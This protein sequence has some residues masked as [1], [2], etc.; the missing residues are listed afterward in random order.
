MA[1]QD[2]S[3]EKTEEPTEK[4]LQDAKKK[5]Q[6]PRSR[7]LNTLLSLVAAAISM[8]FLGQ[9]LI[10]DLFDLMT[11]SLAFDLQVIKNPELMFEQISRSVAHGLGALAPLFALFVFAAF[12]GP[13]AMGGMVIQSRIPC[14]KA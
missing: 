7:D 13:V 4:R 9:M 8:L 12:L 1:D 5:G 3:Q 10:V 14:P 6:V 11:G 2:T